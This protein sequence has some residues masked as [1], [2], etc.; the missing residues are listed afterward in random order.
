[1]KM[2]VGNTAYGQMGKTATAPAEVK[3]YKA[4]KYSP[5]YQL[6]EMP[7]FLAVLSADEVRKYYPAEAA[8]DG[9]EG[10]VMVKLTIDDD[11]SVV[12]VVV[13]ND[14]G[15]GFGEAAR[16]R[17]MRERFKP[18]KVN[19]QAVATEINFTVRFERDD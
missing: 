11:G 4:E 15:H 6:Q 18:G 7:V 16:K 14:P 17:M 1:M 19:G 9:L 8:K 12:K 13:V 3:P 10:E 2:N 5:Q